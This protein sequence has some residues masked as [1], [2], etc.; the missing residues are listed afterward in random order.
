ML[1]YLAVSSEL[2]F[3]E[4][5]VFILEDDFFTKSFVFI[6]TCTDE[7]IFSIVFSEDVN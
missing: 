5:L 2:A 3:Y 4:F 7:Y 1:I 6:N